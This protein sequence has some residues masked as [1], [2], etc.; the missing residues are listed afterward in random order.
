MRFVGIEQSQEYADIAVGRLLLT[1]EATGAREV[2]P[3]PKMIR[4]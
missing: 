4:E 1:L 2:V 3:A